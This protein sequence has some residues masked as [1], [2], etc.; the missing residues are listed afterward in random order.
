MG[1][2]ISKKTAILSKCCENARN[3][4]KGPCCRTC[5]DVG[6][7]HDYSE[8]DGL[9]SRSVQKEKKNK[10]FWNL[11]CIVIQ[12][13]TNEEMHVIQNQIYKNETLWLFSKLETEWIYYI[14]IIS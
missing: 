7:Q 11:I 14:F 12:N 4:F 3:V 9:V 5:Q 10:V 6:I 13:Q 8:S 2:P 1:R